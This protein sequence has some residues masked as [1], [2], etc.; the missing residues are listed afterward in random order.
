[1]PRHDNRNHNHD[2]N[3][4]GGAPGGRRRIRAIDPTGEEVRSR[5][6]GPDWGSERHGGGHG[7][8]PRR[9]EFRGMPGFIGG[10]RGFGGRRAGRGDMRAAVLAL[11]A[12]QPM[13][14]YQMITEIAERSG[15]FWQ[16][17]PGSIYPVLQQLQDEGLVAPDEADG[18]RVFHLTEAGRAYVEAN[19]E[20]LREPWATPV[21]GRHEAAFELFRALGPVASAAKQVVETGSAS[22]VERAR[23]ILTEARKAL[24]RILAEDEQAPEPAS[25]SA[26]AGSP[27]AGEP[28]TASAASES[29]T[30]SPA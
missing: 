25:E 20:Q 27:S 5:R 28:G 22:Q 9:G 26:A 16:P 19:S 21:G 8:G 7:R 14:G 3:H 30:N 17:S 1:M 18:R 11:L 12:E 23:Q 4:E 6:H 29:A 10:G 15:G 24:Y 2:H 13:H